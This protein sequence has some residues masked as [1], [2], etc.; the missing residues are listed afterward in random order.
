MICAPS[1]GR[2]RALLAAGG[3]APSEPADPILLMPR[4]GPPWAE[5]VADGDLARPV[6]IV[7]TS[8]FATR[9]AALLSRRY[10]AF[11]VEGHG[12]SYCVNEGQFCLGADDRFGGAPE[13][14]TCLG[15]YAC[16]SA[17]H[18][19]AAATEL[20]ADLL[21]LDACE[22]GSFVSPSLRWTR[23]PMTIPIMSSV[24]ALVASDVAICRPDGAIDRVHAEA[25]DSATLGE[26]VVRLNA[27]RAGGNPPMPYH[28]LGDPDAACH[29]GAV[30]A[31]PATARTAAAADGQ[32][33]ALRRALS[34]L[35]GLVGD[36]AAGHWDLER[37]AEPVRILTEGCVDRPWPFGLW[38]MHDQCVLLRGD[39]CPLCGAPQSFERRYVGIDGPRSMVECA[40]CRLVSDR[41]AGSPGEI[42]L[43]IRDEL[44][45]S[46]KD[47]EPPSIELCLRA[48]AEPVDA[49]V[50]L[51]LALPG[52]AAMIESG[53]ATLR[54][55]PGEQ[56]T[57]RFAISHTR[58]PHA[59]IHFVRAIALL[60]G[61]F[62]LAAGPI[63]I[64]HPLA[65]RAAA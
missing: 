32:F 9:R 7:P 30:S 21:V 41:P 2:L 12:R 61:R 39:P 37:L 5:E 3:A 43:R 25:V 45:A 18:L 46:L 44:S 53:T 10:S 19:R 33:D 52:G 60:N 64:P 57:L 22:A 40:G 15:R 24:D 47:G 54:L 38:P 20:R 27:V 17:R 36:P 26:F 8:Q 29:V 14:R 28:L 34:A 31:E 35:R 51:S 59:Q 55:R 4:A 58:P 48:H 63:S 50:A 16:A 13:A 65:K 62:V 49:A 23:W 11:F 56:K 6:A 42:T 1:L